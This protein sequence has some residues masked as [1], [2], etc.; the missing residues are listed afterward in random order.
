MTRFP[1]SLLA[2]GTTEQYQ[3][4]KGA[5]VES[6]F[7]TRLSVVPFAFWYCS[8]VPFAKRDHRNRVMKMVVAAVPFAKRVMKMAAVPFAK[9]DRGALP[10]E[11]IFRGHPVVPFAKCRQVPRNMSQV[12]RNMGQVPRNMGQVPRNTGQVPPSAA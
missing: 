4:A 7:M 10:T 1:W 2:K 9:R 5:T 12:P 8:V 3:N 11:S 6:I